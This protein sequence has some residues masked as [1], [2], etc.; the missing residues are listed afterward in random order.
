MPSG[1]PPL[2]WIVHRDEAARGAL[3]RLLGV[4]DAVV[5]RPGDAVFEEMPRADAVVLG[6]AASSDPSGASGDWEAELEFVHKHR[7]RLGEVRWV[8]CGGKDDA[9]AA[10]QLFDR[11]PVDFLAWPPQPDALRRA[12]RPAS[13]R[14]PP[15]SQRARRELVSAR[16]S[17]WLGDLELPELLRLLDPRLADLPVLVEGEPG[18]GRSTLIRYAHHFGSAA[19]GSLAHVPCAPDLGVPEIEAA[20]V[21]LCRAKPRLAGISV[22]LDDPGR[23]PARVQRELAA[24]LDAGPPPGVRTPRLRW[25]ASVDATGEPLE[26][27]LRR[28]LG[29]IALRIAPLRERPERIEALVRDVTRSWSETRREPPRGLDPSAMAFVREYP[30][31]GNARELEAMLQQTLAS[32]SRDPLRADDLILDGR[33]LAPVEASAV[34]TLLEDEPPPPTSGAEAT[35][36]PL[37]GPG[38]WVPG[39]PDPQQAEVAPTALPVRREAA[40]SRVGLDAP[41]RLPEPVLELDAETDAGMRRLAHALIHQVRN[42]LATIRTFAELLPERFDDPDFRARFPQMVREDVGRIHGLLARLE[43]LAALDAPLRDKLDVSGLLEELL[44]AR[45][46]AFRERHLLVLKELD[47]SRPAA[48]AD[49]GHLRL[50]FEALLDRA[51]ATIPERGD[52]YIA[53]RRH[54]GANGESAVRVLLRFADP[55]AGRAGSTGL[56]NSIEL[57]VAELVVRAQGGRFTVG[58]S[59]A[60][61]RI[62]V[63]DLPSP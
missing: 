44:E 55:R 30:W 46:D 17:R 1:A 12:T 42:P 10:Q 24:W 57:L 52:L 35:S 40:P 18:S 21:D 61:E 5:G 27:V 60:E 3:V 2:I 6:L 7:A 9:E 20:L 48:L 39:A 45:R 59:E 4:S 63:V 58:A 43:A 41:V 38:P 51:L 54:D 37:H 25:L 14:R 11:I 36:A 31:P 23:L 16:F 19:D 29:V 49:P 62:L 33:V 13:P 15:L 22:W 47:S 53:S 50:A 26:P 28:A 32:T 8:L 56:E 34:G